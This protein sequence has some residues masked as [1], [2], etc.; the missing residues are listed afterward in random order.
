MRHVC[1]RDPTTLK[2]RAAAGP[3]VPRA[4]VTGTAR[5]ARERTR[6][7][8]HNER[9]LDPRSELQ[10]FDV[11]RVRC[12]GGLICGAQHGGLRDCGE[13]EG[14]K[15]RTVR[16]KIE[17]SGEESPLSSSTQPHATPQAVQ[18]ARSAAHGG[19]FASSVIEWRSPP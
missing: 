1:V 19:V 9:Q 15:K 18:I 5:V 3:T 8:P 16:L 12:A 11:Q 10:R 2:T 17:G 4:P 14:S 6:I 7:S 13:P